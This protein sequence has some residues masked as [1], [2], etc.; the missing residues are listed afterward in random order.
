MDLNSN[1]KANPKDKSEVAMELKYS[2]KASHK[3]NSVNEVV[4]SRASLNRKDI[5]WDTVVKSN[6]KASLRDN[7][8]DK[9]VP[10]YNTRVNLK[11]SLVATELKY[12]ASR[13]LKDSSV[14]DLAN[15]R[16]KVKYK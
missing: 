16:V 7:L 15:T 1:T 12:K 14:K 13:N 2:T 11:D 5:S 4:S 8:A 9:V 10:R 6:T 3:D